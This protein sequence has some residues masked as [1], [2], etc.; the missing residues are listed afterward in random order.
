MNPKP[1]E[2]ILDMCAGLG[3][4]S[5][6]MAALMKNQGNILSMDINAQKLVLANEHFKRLGITICKTMHGD[7][8]KVV[9]L[10][11]LY[12]R[13]L[14]DAPCSGLGPFDDILKLNGASMF[15]CFRACQIAT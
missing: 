13:V 2:D 4:K 15:Q 3:G 7:S 5:A 6:H 11:P 10:E 14:V 9:Q 12:D 1:G 8:K